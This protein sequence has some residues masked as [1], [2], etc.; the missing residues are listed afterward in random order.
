MVAL[1]QRV[2]EASVKIAGEIS[3]SIGPGPGM[4]IFIGIHVTDTVKELT[5]LVKKCANLRIF[6][7]PDHKMNLSC[8]DV[9]AE[10]L[11]V[12]Q[13]TLYANTDRGNRPSYMESARG[14]VARP[15]YEQFIIE[16]SRTLKNPVESGEF[17]AMMD[18]SLVNDGP[19]TLWVEKKAADAG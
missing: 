16:L 15:L 5:W 18:V 11:V 8:L 12:S 2:S 14:E 19:V 7:D 1:V 4:L 9:G 6:N 10:V 17:G 13:F 3:G